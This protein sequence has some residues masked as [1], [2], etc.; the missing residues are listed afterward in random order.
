M[1]C[2]RGAQ[3]FASLTRDP[4]SLISV[5]DTNHEWNGQY[6]SKCFIK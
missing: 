6:Y 3:G 1:T 5:L 2:K 4:L